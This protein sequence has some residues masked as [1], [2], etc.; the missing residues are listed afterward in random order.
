MLASVGMLRRVGFS[1]V[2]GRSKFSKNFRKFL[3][4]RKISCSLAPKSVLPAT[5]QPRSNPQRSAK[6][7]ASVGMLPRRMEL[8]A[9]VRGRFRT[10]I[11]ENFCAA[12]KFRGRSRR[13]PSCPP[14]CSLAATRRGPQ[15]CWQA[16]ACCG[17]WDCMQFAADFGPKFSKIFRKFLRGRKI[18][19]SIA[20]KSVLPAA[21]QSLC[22]PQRSSRMLDSVGMLRRVGLRAV[23]GR[24]RIE[25]FEKF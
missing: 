10:E 2:R 8:H 18:S 9:G 13:N 16:S 6:M 17:A 15:E 23:R 4:G 21:A 20:P 7:L 12:A 11:F 25:I 14:P 22:H 3:R 1:A 19:R 24:F 5:M